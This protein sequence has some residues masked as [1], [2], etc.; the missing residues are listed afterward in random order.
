MLSSRFVFKCLQVIL[1]NLDRKVS[2]E[3]GALKV[4]QVRL[5]IQVIKDPL[6]NQ[7]HRDYLE[8]EVNPVNLVHLGRQEQ[9][10]NPVKSV[11]LDLPG[12]KDLQEVPV[13]QDLL[14]PLE[15]LD[16]LDLPVLQDKLVILG[17]LGLRVPQAIEV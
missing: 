4:H 9:M 15:Q 8:I 13:N 12:H 1:V 11:L 3:I 10:A 7:G 17:S 14:E 5:V 2:Q 6:D 16:P